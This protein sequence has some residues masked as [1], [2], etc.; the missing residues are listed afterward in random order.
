MNGRKVPNDGRYCGR[1]WYTTFV[2]QMEKRSSPVLSTSHQ[3]A[4]R[5]L[6][7]EGDIGILASMS[8]ILPTYGGKVW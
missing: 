1:C 3:E 7:L 8:T 4:L 6:R 5:Y 2:V